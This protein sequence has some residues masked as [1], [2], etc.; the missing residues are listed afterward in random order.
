MSGNS[1]PVCACTQVSIF[2]ASGL[3]RFADKVRIECGQPVPECRP[4]IGRFLHLLGYGIL[5]IAVPIRAEIPAEELDG[6]DIVIRQHE[7]LFLLLLYPAEIETPGQSHILVHE[8]ARSNIIALAIGLGIKLAGRQETHPGTFGIYY[9]ECSFSRNRSHIEIAPVDAHIVAT[10][11]E[12]FL[13][14]SSYFQIIHAVCR[15]FFQSH[16]NDIQ[17]DC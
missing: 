2:L 3:T 16:R 4:G 11:F 5:T 9:R 8:I 17:V 13:V 1:L 10:L 6:I 7:N 15:A 14:D 12:D